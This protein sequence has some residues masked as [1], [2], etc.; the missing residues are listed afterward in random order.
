MVKVTQ[1]MGST[2]DT[3]DYPY[4]LLN[5]ITKN[6]HARFSTLQK[7]HEGRLMHSLNHQEEIGVMLYN[8]NTR[9]FIDW[10]LKDKRRYEKYKDNPSSYFENSRRT[11]RRSS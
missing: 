1:F 4:I 5:P 8:E 11:R 7:A 3:K 6:I 2:Y 10:Q 9:K